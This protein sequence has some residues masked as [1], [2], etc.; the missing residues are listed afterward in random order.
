MVQ[1]MLNSNVNAAGLESMMTV[2]AKAAAAIAG[3][4]FVFFSPFIGVLGAF[5]SGSNTVS[6]I[7][8]ASFQFETASILGLPQVLIVALQTV[9]GAV[10]NMI[11]VNNVVAA[12]ATVGAIG[13]EGVLIRRNFIPCVIYSVYAA[14]VVAILIALGVNP[15]PINV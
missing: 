9:G 1:L 2:M 10:G 3:N 7:L 11:C 14:I 12:V 13:A 5:I 6:N 15:F 8:F 4:A